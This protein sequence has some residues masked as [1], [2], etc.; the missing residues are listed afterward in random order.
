MTIETPIGA[1]GEINRLRSNT[2]KT[3]DMGDNRRKIIAAASPIHYLDG[4]T[5]SEI[6]TTIQDDGSGNLF[7]SSA[8]FTFQITRNEIGYRYTSRSGGV[9]IVKLLEVNNSP[10]SGPF[11][12]TRFSNNNIIFERVFTDC[13]IIMRVWNG[14]VE[15]LKI[16]HSANAPTSFTWEITREPNAKY[17]IVTDTKGWDNRDNVN[18][19]TEVRN[20]RSIELT[21]NKT[22]E[23]DVTLGRKRFNVTETFT[24]RTRIR[25]A[26]T[27][28]PRWVN[29][30]IYPVVIDQDVTESIVN[31]ADD[32][33]V[34]V[35]SNTMSTYTALI[36]SELF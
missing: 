32:V 26:T 25:D 16:L 33:G 27:R 34:F 31:D 21:H 17:N 12:P 15:I 30:I 36:P 29:E 28:V 20:R 4:A 13:D 35:N 22:T 7:V 5:F 9:A 24:G 3:F 10:V 23:Q 11:T 19:P 1:V 18:R 8:P 6:D 2:S 14:K